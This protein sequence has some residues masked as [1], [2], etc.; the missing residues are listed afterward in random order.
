M[1]RTIVLLLALAL[2]TAAAWQRRDAYVL[3]SGKSNITMM[4]GMTIDALVALHK[5]LGEDTPYLWARIAGREYLIRDEAFL[6]QA[7]AL[8]APVRAL[9]PE[10]KALSA[11][12]KRLDDRIDAIED[13]EAKAAPGELE[14]LRARNR[15]VS[16]RMRELDERSEALE[17]GVEAKLQEMIEQAIRDGRAKTLR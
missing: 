7:D 1:R 2:T 16:Q 15:A 11:E 3:H 10:E 13:G 17:K 14:R 6:R 5:R 4:G 9:K 12:E 8:W